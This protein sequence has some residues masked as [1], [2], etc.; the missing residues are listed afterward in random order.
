[1]SF[2]QMKIYKLW[3]TEE[4]RYISTNLFSGKFNGPS[5]D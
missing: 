5:M 4:S 3:M 2:N 1:M